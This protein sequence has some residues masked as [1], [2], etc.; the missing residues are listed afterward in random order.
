MLTDFVKQNLLQISASVGNM[1]NKK[2]CVDDNVS[3]PFY[4]ALNSMLGKTE[5]LKHIYRNIAKKEVGC[6]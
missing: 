3:F 2:K 6:S 4:T 5:L 1:S